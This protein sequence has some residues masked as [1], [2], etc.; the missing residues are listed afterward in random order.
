[1]G[2]MDKFPS[3]APST[4]NPSLI[5]CVNAHTRRAKPTCVSGVSSVES[6]SG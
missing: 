6:E 5:G 1:M 4:E 3:G 2:A